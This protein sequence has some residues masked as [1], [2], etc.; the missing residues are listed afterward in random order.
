M[1]QLPENDPTEIQ[2]LIEATRLES[3]DEIRRASEALRKPTFKEQVP[4]SSLRTETSPY[5]PQF[6]PPIARLCILDDEDEDGEWLRIRGD[7]FVIG[8]TEGNLVIPHDSMI[9]GRHAELSR[10]TDKGRVVWYL[11]DLQSTNGTYVRVGRSVLKH[12]QQLLIGARRYR[13]EIASSG[14]PA[15]S[16][17][18][19]NKETQ[20]WQA[21]AP[22]SPQFPAL[23]ELTPQGESQRHPLSG[24]DHWIGRDANQCSIFL[25]NDPMVDP[26]HAHI[27]RDAQGR[28]QIENNRSLNGIWI[29]IN[30]VPF[31]SSGQ[32]QMGEQRFLLRIG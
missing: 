26:R 12:H 25:A 14:E 23:V 24:T 21:Q 7:K 4:D 22:Y 31:S 11:T 16:E 32:F 17:A 18:A 3:L 19:T 9:S 29:R 28:W 1:P 2:D 15:A 10:K 27:Y 5:R 13:F 8:R 20:G 6:R 30:R